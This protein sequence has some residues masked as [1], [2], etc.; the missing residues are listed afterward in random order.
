MLQ[1]VEAGTLTE[2]VVTRWYR[3]PELLCES[4]EYGAAIDVWSVGCIMGEL[5]ARRPILQ[6]SS[7]NQQLQLIIQ[8]LGTPSEEELT[9][10]ESE[11]ARSVIESMGYRPKVRNTVG[12]ALYIVYKN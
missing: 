11:S 8:L 2:Y 3:A 6:G 12:P 10:I 7:T 5:L 1:T 9:S 4:K